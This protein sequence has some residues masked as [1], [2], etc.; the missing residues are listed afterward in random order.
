[1]KR[2]YKAVSVEDYNG[3]YQICL[4]GRP[5]RSPAKAVLRVPT[6]ELAEAVQAEGLAVEDE[7]QPDDM[8]M[9][10]M[11]VTVVDRVTPQREALADELVRYAID[12]VLRYRSADD[13]ELAARQKEVWDPWLSW[14]SQ[15]CGL[16]LSTT[17]G[18]MPACADKEAEQ[19]LKN[20]FAPLSDAAFGCL[21]RAATLSGSVVLGLA[22][23]DRQMPADKLFE[24]AFL[25]ELYQNGLWGT[26]SEAESRQA[27]IR[28]ELKDVE[29]FMNM[30]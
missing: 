28:S 21:Y 23:Q 25:D 5:V 6:E 9:H 17:N 20:R 14:A 11:M 1:M 24:T 3:G 12:D 10:A 4:D 7:I 29:R 19:I 13:L 16:V 27:A 18:L 30:L 15:Q 2:F 8:P 22:F 26:D